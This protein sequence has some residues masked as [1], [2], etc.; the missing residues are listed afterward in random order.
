MTKPFKQTTP[1]PPPAPSTPVAPHTF[2]V[3]TGITAAAQRVVL[4]GVGGIGKTTLAS[5]APSPVI[6]DLNRGADRIEVPKVP[7]DQ[8]DT[9]DRVRGLLQH[10]TFWNDYRTCVL[11]AG[12]DLERLCADWVIK[13]VKHE[14]GK[15]INAI[16]DYGFGKG[17]EHIGDAFDKVIG[18]FDRL[19]DRGVNIILVCH[20]VTEKVPNPL[21]EDH[22][23]YQPLLQQPPKRGRNRDRVKG[24]CDHMLYVNYD[25]MVSDGKATGQG[26]RTIYPTERPTYWAKS[27]CLRDPIDFIEGSD[28]VW[29]KIGLK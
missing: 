19:R 23:Q 18:D 8:I 16:E 29:Q 26:T 24:W 28:E 13:N 17:L 1:P 15:A 6:L 22:L 27:R 5:L 21:G 7:F 4:Y 9:L 2:T 20:E 25:K 10:P 14:K 3:K 12:S 11:D